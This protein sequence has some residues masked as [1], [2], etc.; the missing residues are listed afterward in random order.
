MILLTTV[1]IAIELC[2]ILI[3]SPWSSLV[4]KKNNALRPLC[5]ALALTE[6]GLDP[7]EV[8]AWAVESTPAFRRNWYFA[9][10]GLIDHAA[11][12]GQSAGA[13]TVPST[14]KV[15]KSPAP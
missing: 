8:R 12:N 7:P 3:L 9:E 5:H 13:T 15:A 4:M 2:H 6:I 14:A 11:S 1:V 10:V